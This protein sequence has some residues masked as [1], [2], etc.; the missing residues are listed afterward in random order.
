MSDKT[1]FKRRRE[2]LRKRGLCV[3]CGQEK[4]R[5]GRSI[6]EKCEQE[7]KVKRLVAPARRVVCEK[8]ARLE[9][10]LVFA[11]EAER[12]ILGKLAELKTG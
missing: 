6:G 5:P 3:R 10:N 4:A 9:R 1:R 12:A 8:I 11:Q 7:I 2:L